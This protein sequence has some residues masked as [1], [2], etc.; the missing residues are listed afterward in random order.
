MSAFAVVGL[1]HMGG[2]MA[3]ALVRAGHRVPGVDPGAGPTPDGVERM[4]LAEALAG[5][6][7]IVLSLPGTEQVDQILPALDQAPHPLLVIDASTWGGAAFGSFS[8]AI[9][10]SRNACSCFG[11]VV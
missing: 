9:C 8:A 5:A 6:R 7:T 11:A 10:S 2:G 1:G 3:A 4:E